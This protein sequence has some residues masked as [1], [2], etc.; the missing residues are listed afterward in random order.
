M[1]RREKLRVIKEKK[2]HT[3]EPRGRGRWVLSKNCT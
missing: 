1:E 2:L 3:A